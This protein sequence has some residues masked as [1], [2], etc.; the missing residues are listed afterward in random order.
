MGDATNRGRGRRF[1]IVVVRFN[2]VVASRVLEG[3]METLNAAG[4][5]VIEVPA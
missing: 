3:A 2:E 1:A 5:E 4:V